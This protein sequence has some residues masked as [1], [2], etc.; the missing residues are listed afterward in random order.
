MQKYTI[1][2]PY[3][4]VVLPGLAKLMGADYVPG[5]FSAAEDLFV[6]SGEDSKEWLLTG[7]SGISARVLLEKYEGYL[8][9]EISG[10]GQKFN[11]SKEYLYSRYLEFGGNPIAQDKP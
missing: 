1:C 10:E 4:E 5:D 3:I 8:W 7:T 11:E 2:L 9:I 6:K